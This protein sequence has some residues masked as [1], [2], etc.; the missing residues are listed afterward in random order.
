MHGPL[1]LLRAAPCCPRSHTVS[2]TR[3]ALNGSCIWDDTG[4]R[5]A[6]LCMVRG[7]KNAAAREVG[8]LPA[9]VTCLHARSHAVV[10]LQVRE[11]Q[12]IQ[13]VV[14]HQRNSKNGLWW[15]ACGRIS[16]QQ[17]LIASPR[18]LWRRAILRF[19][20]VVLH[21]DELYGNV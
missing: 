1:T 19:R 9:T 11:V 5:E 21:K 10:I 7:S 4:C 2:G 13:R 6:R 18:W 8:E 12:C 17:P 15:H 14:V 3:T 16:S 20:A